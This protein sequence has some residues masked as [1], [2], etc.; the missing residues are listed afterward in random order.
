MDKAAPHPT[1]QMR[2][3]AL[4]LLLLLR[5]FVVE[6]H[7]RVADLHVVLQDA[8]G[9]EADVKGLDVVD[10]ELL[11]R[12]GASRLDAEAEGADFGQRDAVAVADA[13]DELLGD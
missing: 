2:G 3:C 8:A 11:L 5:L 13:V 4:G 12:L 1:L 9:L 10:D 7:L 6:L